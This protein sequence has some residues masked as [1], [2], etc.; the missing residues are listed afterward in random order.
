VGYVSKLLA[1]LDREHRE[2]GKERRTT[3]SGPPVLVELLSDRELEV[4]RLL[5]TH[6]TSTEIA[7]ELVISANT[8]R[9]HI[10]SVYGKLSVHSRKDAVQRAR[11]LELL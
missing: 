7:E 8:V 4:L 1:E 6:L 10:K 3:T 9:T 5:T 11:E 2:L